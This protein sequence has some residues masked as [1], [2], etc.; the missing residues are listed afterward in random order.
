[1]AEIKAFECLGGFDEVGASATLVRVKDDLGNNRNILIDSGVK[2]RTGLDD[3]GERFSYS[4]GHIMPDYIVHA[5]LITHAHSDHTGNIPYVL[6]ENPEASIYMTVPTSAIAMQLWLNTS[7]IKEQNEGVRESLIFSD[8]AAKACEKITKIEKPG[9]INLF[10]GVDAFYW[11][12]GHIRGSAM[13]FLKVGET[14]TCFSGDMSF[15]D[16]PTVRGMEMPEEFVGRV[17]HLFIESTY[18][19]RS[20]VERYPE[21]D[22]LAR[23]ASD[24]MNGNGKAVFPA[25]GVGRG[26]DVFLALLSRG[27]K[28]FI[29]GMCVTMFDVYASKFGYWSNLDHS[30]GIDLNSGEIDLLKI[31]NRAQ[32]MEILSSGN[33]NPLAVVTTAGMMVRGS[34]AQAH[35]T[36][37]RFLERTRNMLG[38]TGYQAPLTEGYEIFHAS[39][40]GGIVNVYGD[41]INLSARVEKFEL[42]SHADGLQLSGFVKNLNPKRVILNHGEKNGREGLEKLILSN[43]FLGSIIKPSNGNIISF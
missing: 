34:C 37:G 10:P 5:V 30:S 12:N 18:G 17:D 25:F 42:T 7:Y 41:E 1:M 29:D 35:L 8:A 33:P 23:I 36:S 22:R 15:Y 14:I 16:T 43:G 32:R 26:P 28:P 40:N 3:Y 9:W 38:I 21:E 13:I 19:D 6:K 27:L 24:V 2:T 20:I 39:Q 11:P 4:E 31:Y